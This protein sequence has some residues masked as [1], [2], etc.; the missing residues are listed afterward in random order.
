VK[1]QLTQ[2]YVKTP[3]ACFVTQNLE[4]ILHYHQTVQLSI[5]QLYHMLCFKLST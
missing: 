2:D 4:T 3:E 5:C 1:S